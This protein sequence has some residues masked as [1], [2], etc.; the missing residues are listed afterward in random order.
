MTDR[1]ELVAGSFFEYVPEGGDAYVLSRI[2]HDWNDELSAQILVNIRRAMEADATLFIV[3]RVL[4]AMRPSP[5][6]VMTD[7][8]MMVMNGG[9]ERTEKD[10]GVLLNAAGFRLERVIETPMLA[11]ILTA[12]ANDLQ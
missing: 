4:D 3:E 8:N 6:A 11:S 1:C 10:F 2:L 9:R 7:L 5:E 12:R